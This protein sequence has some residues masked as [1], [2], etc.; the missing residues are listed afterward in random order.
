[1]KTVII[2]LMMC[3]KVDTV[4]VKKPEMNPIYTHDI[5]E[6]VAKEVQKMIDKD[7]VVIVYQDKRVTCL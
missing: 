1:M 6:E 7:S 5:T 4:I 2:F 3:G